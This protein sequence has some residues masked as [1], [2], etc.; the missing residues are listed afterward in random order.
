MAL[1]Q[2]PNLKQN[3]QSQVNNVRLNYDLL[4]RSDKMIKKMNLALISMPKKQ[5]QRIVSRRRK[6]QPT[7]TDPIKAIT[8]DL[9][10][11]IF[12][13]TS[14][15]LGDPNN[16]ITRINNIEY[17]KLPFN[18][19]KEAIEK[20]RRRATTEYQEA[21]QEQSIIDEA[22]NFEFRGAI[23]KTAIGTGAALVGFVV[24]PFLLPTILPSWASSVLAAALYTPQLANFG[25]PDFRLGL[26]GEHGNWS[27]NNI[28]FNGFTAWN[29]TW[30]LYG[31]G[32]ELY[33]L[34]ESQGLQGLGLAS[35][36]SVKGF[37]I[38]GMTMAIGKIPDL[39]FGYFFGVTGLSGFIGKV[40]ST[41][42]SN[43]I[44]GTLTGMRIPVSAGSKS[45]WASFAR[46]YNSIDNRYASIIAA[47]RQDAQRR[48]AIVMTHCPLI[49]TGRSTIGLK[50]KTMRDQAMGSSWK[51][52]F[53]ASSVYLTTI[54]GMCFYDWENFTFNPLST[55]FL[56]S[57]LKITPVLANTLIMWVQPQLQKVIERMGIIKASVAATLRVFRT[58]R[59]AIG[60]VYEKIAPSW[61]G[62][63]FNLVTKSIQSTRIFKILVALH[64]FDYLYSLNDEKVISMIIGTTVSVGLLTSFQS[65]STVL[66]PSQGIRI[67]K[68]FYAMGEDD[69]KKYNTTMEEVY[70]STDQETIINKTN[71]TLKLFGINVP[72][73]ELQSVMIKDGEILDNVLKTKPIVGEETVDEWKERLRGDIIKGWENGVDATSSFLQVVA[74]PFQAGGS[75]IYSMGS[76]MTHLYGAFKSYG[77][78]LR[79]PSNGLQMT[80]RALEIVHHIS[81]TADG[82]SN[83]FLETSKLFKD[84]TI[85]AYKSLAS[86]TLTW[87]QDAIGA[88]ITNSI[89]NYILTI[90][91]RNSELITEPKFF[92]VV[93]DHWMENGLNLNIP[94]IIHGYRHKRSIDNYK[95]SIEQDVPNKI[96]ELH[97]KIN[98]FDNI[99][100]QINDGS[101]NT[102]I[103]ID[104]L[105]RINGV[106]KKMSKFEH[107][108]NLV[109][110]R[111]RE[112]YPNSK[113]S[114]VLGSDETINDYVEFYIDNVFDFDWQL[115]KSLDTK[116]NEIMKDI[117]FDGTDGKVVDETI[118]S[119]ASNYK[120]PS[121]QVNGVSSLLN[122]HKVIIASTSTDIENAE[123]IINRRHAHHTSINKITKDEMAN[124][125]S[126]R[127]STK[128]LKSKV[129]EQQSAVESYILEVD[130]LN[131]NIFIFN[132][133]LNNAVVTGNILNQE[134]RNELDKELREIENL[135]NRLYDRAQ[136]LDEKHFKDTTKEDNFKSQVD[137]ESKTLEKAIQDEIMYRTNMGLDTSDYASNQS[138]TFLESLNQ[139]VNNQDRRSTLLDHIKQTDPEK[140]KQ[141]ANYFK[142]LNADG[143][144][145]VA[146]AMVDN[147]EGLRPGE[148]NNRMNEMFGK[149]AMSEYWS[150][151]TDNGFKKDI[152]MGNI[153]RFYEKFKIH[154]TLAHKYKEI[155]QETYRNMSQEKKLILEKSLLQ[156][157]FN[158]EF[159]KNSLGE[160][161]SDNAKSS[162]WHTYGKFASGVTQWASDRLQRGNVV[163]DVASEYGSWAVGAMGLS[164]LAAGASSFFSTMGIFGTGVLAT[165][166]AVATGVGAAGSA[167][168]GVAGGIDMVMYGNRIDA[169]I[170]DLEAID[171]VTNPKKFSTLA[172]ST[173]KLANIVGETDVNKYVELGTLFKNFNEDLLLN[174]DNS[175]FDL[176]L[177]PIKLATQLEEFYTHNKK[178]IELDDIMLNKL[179]ETGEGNKAE[180]IEMFVQDDISDGFGATVSQVVEKG[181]EGVVFDK[182]I[183]PKT[184]RSSTP[185]GSNNEILGSMSLTGGVYGHNFGTFGRVADTIGSTLGSAVGS[186]FKYT[187]TALGKMFGIS[188]VLYNE[189]VPSYVSKE[190]GADTISLGKYHEPKDVKKQFYQKMWNSDEKLIPDDNKAY[191]IDKAKS[192]K[193]DDIWPY[194]EDRTAMDDTHQQAIL[195]VLVG[196][197][198]SSVAPQFILDALNVFN[199]ANFRKKKR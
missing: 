27:L 165:G 41:I 137:Q 81:N 88:M 193:F 43:M 147:L 148:L 175:F 91:E 76:S 36:K 191:W 164:G 71:E 161:L 181:V 29:V 56:Y 67:G 8:Q 125:N 30:R 144:K 33:D 185:D 55:K 26:V 54:A 135:A 14:G 6:K 57:M 19:E 178:R 113:L 95:R 51:Y 188:G 20:N 50:H 126:L 146:N 75:A 162:A 58:T 158:E 118:N 28:I 40:S 160:E 72:E 10:Y 110:N 197:D 127:M 174:I 163:I 64:V 96:A 42:T 176:T 195:G 177:I 69:L 150:Y 39:A 84:T 173:E 61:V 141:Y 172:K 11:T 82:A 90:Q 128:D 89:P 123:M 68:H 169:K 102:G 21:L 53:V 199:F 166:S 2:A 44:R 139:Y 16:D 4:F 83:M 112:K 101:R 79:L 65:L 167:V 59:W 140:Y 5:R 190:M 63:L 170:R 38:N 184:D 179:E 108:L 168:V 104:S 186:T 192:D 103:S 119:Y 198:N 138:K 49:N 77:D 32:T 187:S 115:F 78:S 106:A 196:D 97:N 37:I 3:T 62:G 47:I 171:L 99:V 131:T 121:D 142:S 94:S 136:E 86:T 48:S 98:D 18:S 1:A 129:A 149:S 46:Y 93:W 73:S 132:E 114:D 153:D 15:S 45:K 85:G 23:A 133:H 60:E 52:A 156:T 9:E 116:Y 194:I 120:L 107:D 35:T 109:E 34:I 24:V 74:Y 151:I 92:N 130:N 124:I 12:P 80:L 117:V 100:R 182:Q 105:S 145:T 183:L 17:A 143:L 13:I 25:S 157:G 159:A 189:D 122:N 152:L 180:K 66:R 31:Y 22:V 134:T 87:G 111:Y 7:Q 70:K 154:T 155:T